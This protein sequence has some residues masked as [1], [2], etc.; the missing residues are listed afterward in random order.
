MRILIDIGHPAHVHFFRHAIC[1][2]RQR[3]HEV[4]VT[5]QLKEVMRKLLE[6]FDI[7]HQMVESANLP[8][9][10]R[11]L[12]VMTR[13]LRL[14]K[15]CRNFRPD[16]VT[17]IGGTWAAHAA[18]LQGCPS[19]IWDDTEHHKWG[20]RAC[21]PF[22]TKIYSPDCYLLPKIGKQQLYAGVHE[23]AYLHPNRF[24]P[25][26]KVVREVGLN[27]NQPYCIVRFVG[28]Q[29]VHD[30]GQQG[31]N[32][33]KIVQF[34]QK[35][36]GY[37]QPLITSEKPLSPELKK[38]QLK[39][40]PHQIHHVMAFARLCVGEGATLLSESGILG[41]PG[42][43][44]STIRLGYLDFLEQYGLLKQ[45]TDTDEALQMCLDWLKDP[46]AKEKCARAREEFLKDRIDVTDFI[47]ETLEKHGSKSK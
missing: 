10:L 12:R 26:V 6:A 40:P 47:V 8:P 14:Y 16:V 36:E 27:P 5:V 13:D 21:W 37:A 19:V 1:Q 7:P 44:L 38:Y 25:D 28:W 45:T 22:A 31:F 42:V 32:E 24:A 18:F 46:Q 29:A 39:I 2:L 34:M 43:Y 33:Q 17:A 41:V 20:H 15:A 3:G 30:I 35:L 4:R 23:L 9:W 11:P